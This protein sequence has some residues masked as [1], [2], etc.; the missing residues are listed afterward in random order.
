MKKALFVALSLS[1]VTSAMYGANANTAHASEKA[2]HV[3]EKTIIQNELENLN[4]PV[5]TQEKI[6]KLMES[7]EAKLLFEGLDDYK[8]Y[9]TV[10][11]SG[12]H[13]TKDAKENIPEEIYILLEDTFKQANEFSKGISKSKS[14]LNSS[15]PIV[16][17]PDPGTGGTTYTGKD[18]QTYLYV[19]P[20]NDVGV[21]LYMSDDDTRTIIDVLIYTA[22]ITTITATV[23]ALFKQALPAA[24]ATVCSVIAGTA[25][26]VLSNR[27]KGNGVI[28]RAYSGGS[29]IYSR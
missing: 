7:K 11:E 2:T 23:L 17:A 20:N 8:E 14:K 15:G 4:L 6:Q 16:Y 27:N 22:A 18:K 28:V 24:S 19:G 25:A 12:Y 29:A 3:S 26:S 13:F 10:D 5:E 21:W 1:L 9:Y